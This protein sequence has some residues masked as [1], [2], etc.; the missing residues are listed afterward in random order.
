M[1][2]LEELGRL[3]ELPGWI[4]ELLGTLLEQFIFGEFFALAHRFY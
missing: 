3:L 1:D 4:L 2:L